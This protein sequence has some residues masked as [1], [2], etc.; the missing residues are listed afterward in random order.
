MEKSKTWCTCLVVFIPSW[1]LELK[2]KIRVGTLFWTIVVI[3]RINS[4]W[5]RD[6]A[7]GR[8]ASL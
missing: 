7:K 1:D 3:K 8:G 4:S 6:L 2:G 5:L